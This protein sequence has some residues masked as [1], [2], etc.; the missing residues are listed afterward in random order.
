MKKRG[1][2]VFPRCRIYRQLVICSSLP[3]GVEVIEYTSAVQMYT[4]LYELAVGL[5][6]PTPY[7]TSP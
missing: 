6:S 1:V 7:Y 4:T 3:A 2:G 5:M